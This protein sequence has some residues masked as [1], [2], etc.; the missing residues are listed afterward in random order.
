MCN[1]PFRKHKTWVH[2]GGSCTP[3]IVHWPKG[4]KAKKELR[5]THAHVTDV[6]PTILDVA[7]VLTENLSEVIFKHPDA[8]FI[9]QGYTDSQGNFWYN[10]QLSR[11]RA[12]I[13]K[14]YFLEKGILPSNIEVVGMGSENPIASN[15]TAAGRRKNRRVEIQVILE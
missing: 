7:G 14:S 6:V 11:T 2:E 13:V 4:I 15:E 1:T 9:I 10:K 8:H 5:H 12:E 3:F